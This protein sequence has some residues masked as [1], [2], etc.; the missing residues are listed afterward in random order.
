[1]SR[2]MAAACTAALGA[3]V[4][5][6]PSA[7]HAQVTSISDGTDDLWVKVTDPE[8]FEHTYVETPADVNIDVTKTVVK[9]TAKRIA[10]TAT[11]DDLEK[12]GASTS[13]YWSFF[14]L[15][16]GRR[17]AVNVGFDEDGEM[18]TYITIQKEPGGGYDK[19]LDCPGL[20][21]AVTWSEDTT[22]VSFPRSCYD[23]PAWLR[24]HGSSV[25]IPTDP[26]PGHESDWIVDNA[27][28]PGPDEHVL[29]PS[30]PWTGKLKAG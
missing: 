5:L 24:F 17:A 1:M 3:S 14:K 25:G 8:T 12:G 13:T 21:A 20:K 7:A 23:K 16:D 28:D 11:Y 30:G 2:L 9:H 15:A 29:G 19:N 22:A 26:E 27:H 4:V 10:V 18:S 6:A